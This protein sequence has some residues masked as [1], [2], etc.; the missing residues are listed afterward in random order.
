[1][2]TSPAVPTDI[3]SAL[4]YL[5]EQLGTMR[6]RR[7][8]FLPDWFLVSMYLDVIEHCAAVETL[9][10]S[11]VPHAAFANA[12]SALEAAVE[13]MYL[14]A[15]P[16]AYDERGALGRA[17]ELVALDR[18]ARREAPVADHALGYVAPE[19]A[20]STSPEEIIGEE[21]RIWAVEF[22]GA[23]GVAERALKFA[24]ER[25]SGNWTGLSRSELVKAAAA[26]WGGEADPLTPVWEFLYGHLS[27][28]SHPGMRSG[29]RTHRF[30]MERL[31]IEPRESDRRQLVQP[32]RL[33]AYLAMRAANRAMNFPAQLD[34]PAPP[35]ANSP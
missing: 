17:F 31:V 1:V 3:P 7:R 33:A 27:L 9:T 22:R 2:T 5:N 11:D 25:Q 8:H 23:M 28:E 6:V 13:L 35:V 14:T 12:R 32:V 24:Q 20:E 21:A 15:T 19:T 16:D 29:A 4:A 34:V 10:K 26:A 18:L 30:E